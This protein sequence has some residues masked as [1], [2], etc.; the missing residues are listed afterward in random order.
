VAAL[1]DAPQRGRLSAA[2]WRGA[3]GVFLLVFVSTL[4]V[5]LPFVV[6]PDA[7]RA[8]RVSNAVAVVMLFVAG[9]AYGRSMHRSPVVVGISMVVIGLV[10]VGLT[11]ALGG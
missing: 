8:L 1:P 3:V 7:P 4:P 11:M 5:A 9:A 10:L 6:M 2:D